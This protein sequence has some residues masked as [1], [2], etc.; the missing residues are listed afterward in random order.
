METVIIYKW[1]Q[2]E[3]TIIPSLPSQCLWLWLL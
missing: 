2:L 3:H 1:V